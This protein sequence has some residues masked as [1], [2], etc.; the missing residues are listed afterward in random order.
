MEVRPAWAA[1]TDT[2]TVRGRTRHHHC[3][4]SAHGF[5]LQSY[6]TTAH[7][8]ASAHVPIAGRASHSHRHP[9]TTITTITSPPPTVHLASPLS[10]ATCVTMSKSL[11]SDMTRATWSPPRDSSVISRGSCP[12]P[13]SPHNGRATR[14]PPLLSRADP[15][16]LRAFSLSDTQPTHATLQRHTRPLPP[17]C[18][19]VRNP[20]IVL[21]RGQTTSREAVWPRGHGHHPPHRTQP[22]LTAS[23]LQRATRKK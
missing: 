13:R 6:S 21:H 4:Y 8:Q 12:A 23:C 17:R 10:H 18:G 16:H 15:P 9:A 3:A 1:T 14:A 11:G 22:T 2:R 5:A 20:E 7:Y 19:G